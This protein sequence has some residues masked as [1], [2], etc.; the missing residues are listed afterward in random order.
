MPTIDSKVS[1][2]SYKLRHNLRL[3]VIK[4]CTSI[5]KVKELSRLRMRQT[6]STGHVVGIKIEL[7]EP[8]S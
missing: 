2:Y 5:M 7:I 6:T 4:D 8:S 3:I 1:N